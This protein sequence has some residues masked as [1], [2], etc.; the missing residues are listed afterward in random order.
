M[1]GVVLLTVCV[2]YLQVK[3]I[4]KDMVI[5]TEHNALLHSPFGKT[6]LVLCRNLLIYLNTEGGSQHN[7]MACG[8][9]WSPAVSIEKRP[10]TE[11]VHYGQSCRWA[12]QD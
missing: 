7:A 6:D 4:L 5:F 1:F 8:S 3:Q 2:F 12:Y 11:L 10:S 9:E